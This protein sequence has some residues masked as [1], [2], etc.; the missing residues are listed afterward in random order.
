MHLRRP[1]YPSFCAS[2]FPST[3][4]IWSYIGIA[5]F[6]STR[7][8]VWRPTLLI[9]SSNPILWSLKVFAISFIRLFFLFLLPCQSSQIERYDGIFCLLCSLLRSEV[10]PGAK[11]FAKRI[12][13]YDL[14]C[15]LYPQPLFDI[16]S[17]SCMLIGEYYP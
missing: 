15:A 9:F 3:V 11:S 4:S 16:C 2:F 6:E 10:V 1:S 8:D 17:S 14:L 13:A 7:P 5:N 12:T